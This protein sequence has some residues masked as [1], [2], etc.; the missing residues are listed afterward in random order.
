MRQ[1]E[2]GQEAEGTGEDRSEKS[3][4]KS[5]QGQETVG[6]SRDM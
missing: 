1:S 6:G 5:L 2:Q 3:R 4:I